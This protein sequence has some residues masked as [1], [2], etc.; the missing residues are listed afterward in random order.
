MT[1][2]VAPLREPSKGTPRPRLVQTDVASAGRPADGPG[3][4]RGRPRGAGAKATRDHVCR[5]RA[6]GSCAREVTWR[7]RRRP[8]AEGAGWAARDGGD[9]SSQAP[10]SE[11]LGLGQSPCGS[12]GTAP[13]GFGRPG[14]RG[15]A[16]TRVSGRGGVTVLSPPATLSGRTG[17][18]R[19]RLRAQR[20]RHRRCRGARVR[21]FPEPADAT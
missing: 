1:A 21:G 7:C 19:R 17:G 6:E 10:C 15:A 11:S 12:D 5:E 4:S 14:L 16:Q 3:S 20:A 2:P 18:S 13:V 8:A 9:H